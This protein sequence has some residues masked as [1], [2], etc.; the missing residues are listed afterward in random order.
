MWNHYGPS[1]THVHYGMASL[2]WRARKPGTSAH[3]RAD[4]QL[5][6]Y[7]LSNEWQPVP[8]GVTGELYLGGAGVARGYLNRPG[9]TAERFVPDPFT[10]AG[11]P[12][13]I[14]PVTWGGY[15]TDGTI[16]FLG[17]IDDQVKMRGFRIELGEIEAR[18][19]GAPGGARSGGSGAGGA[20]G[21]QATGG[22][23]HDG[24]GRDASDVSTGGGGCAS[25]GGAAGVHGACG[26]CVA[27]GAAA[28][29]ER[30]AGS[31]GAA[32]ARGDGLCSQWLRGAGGRDR[33]EA[34][35][36]IWAEVLRVERVGRHDDFFELGGHSL[37]AVQW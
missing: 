3:R 8:V 29:A 32:G 36:A 16:E 5:P 33:D 34:L 31:Q 30:Q 9:Q 37:L 13:C 24:D 25:I 23:L 15:L 4:R 11:A 2:E 27:G 10:A 26:V 6:A 35:A 19:S 28:D 1:E 22:V 18:L 12:A 7:I 14:A 21:R 17:R 20:G